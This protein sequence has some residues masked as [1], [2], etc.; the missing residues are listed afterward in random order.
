M[1]GVSSVGVSIR[2]VSYYIFVHYFLIK[3]TITALTL[4]G[5]AKRGV[6]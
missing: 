5:V 3:N 2:G 1:R 4:G 6:I